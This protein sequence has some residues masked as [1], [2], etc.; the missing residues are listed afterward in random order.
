MQGVRDTLVK[1]DDT[2]RLAG[3]LPSL[4]RYEK[5]DGSHSLPLPE[6]GA[7][8]RVTQAVL[9]FADEVSRARGDQRS[10]PEGAGLS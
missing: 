10:A 1:P 5:V 2:A 7:W 3:R 6:G 8:E 4:R 9:R